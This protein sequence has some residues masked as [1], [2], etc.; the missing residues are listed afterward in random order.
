[1]PIHRFL[2]FAWRH[3]LADF[4]RRNFYASEIN[5]ETPQKSIWS[6]T[7]SLVMHV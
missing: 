7:L 5:L 1:L 6:G 4:D 2:D 3:D